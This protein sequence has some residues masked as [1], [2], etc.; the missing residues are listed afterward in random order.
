MPTDP[1]TAGQHIIMGLPGPEL[2]DSLRAFIR[3]IQPGGFIFFTRNLATPEQTFALLAELRSLCE[4]PPILTIDQEGGRV[5]RLKVIGEEPPSAQEIRKT[6]RLDWCRE[7]GELMG[8]VQAVF[9]LNL[10]LAP[11]VDYSPDDEADNSLKGR[12]WGSTPGETVE[13]ALLF[14]EGMQSRGVAGTAKHFPGYTHCRLDPHGDLPRVDRTR[15]QIEAEEM[16]A[17]RAFLDRAEAFMIGHGHFPA[18]HADPYPASL[19]RA[20][21]HDY[22]RG[23]LGYKGLIMTDDLEMGAIA[24]RYGSAE[25]ARLALEAGEDMLLICH[26]PACV[27]IAYDALCALPEQTTGRALA[28]VRAFKKTL[29]PAPATFDALRFR[30]VNE[31]IRDLRERVRTHVPA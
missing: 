13:K 17:F 11:V 27:E 12:C 18:W 9:G 25:S 23:E 2:T 24:N 7:H 15:A 4:T 19:S 8:E 1:R 30:R 28:S 21:V 6:G 20:I 31:A 3:R 10:D 14:L 16:V 5:S 22:L 26:N 29:P